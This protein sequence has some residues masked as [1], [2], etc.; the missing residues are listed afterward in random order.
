MSPL[1]ETLR[2]TGPPRIASFIVTVWGDAVAPRG[3]SLWLGSLQ[4]ILD[5]FG[6]TPGQ[7]RTAMSR[8]TE[9]GWL[10][11]NRV[12]RLSFYRL[13]PRGE[14]SFA[15]AAARIYATAP[16]D[17]DGTFRLLLA[18]R[19]AA[20]EALAARGFAALPP[21]R[22]GLS[23]TEA[24]LPADAPLLLA[25]PRSTAEARELAAR[26]WPLAP[27]G[28]FYARFLH[29]FAPLRDAAPGIP[30]AEALPLRLLL[31]HEW[32]RAVLR[33]PGLPE[34]LLPPDWPGHEAR[35]LTI[36]LY[37]RLSPGAEAWLDAEGRNESGLLPPPRAARF[38]EA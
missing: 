15:A 25:R 21:F 17:W 6:C 19:P 37:R 36:A 38:T 26:A 3:G 32:R 7:V 24:D 14:T 35:A 22:I 11:R 34:A 23:G 5:R 27:L 4:A 13:G 9:E 30:P 33:D 20:E 29:A 18:P 12:G 28:A 8:L 16:P 2:R 10:V 31:V 1:A